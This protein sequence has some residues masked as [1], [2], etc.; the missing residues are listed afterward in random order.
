MLWHVL[1]NGIDQT[2][3]QNSDNDGCTVT[4]F[5]ASVE[6]NTELG[7]FTRDHFSLYAEFPLGDNFYI[8]KKY[9]PDI[10]NDG[11]PHLTP[12]TTRGGP[13]KTREEVD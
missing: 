12:V 7:I 11:R 5:E 6:Q 3:G 2:L 1:A 10:K 8:T 13:G 4:Y 9:D